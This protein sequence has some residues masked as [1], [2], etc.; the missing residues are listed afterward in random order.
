VVVATWGTD[1]MPVDKELA[2]GRT[3]RYALLVI[4]S[5][6]GTIGLL[7]ILYGQSQLRWARTS[8]D[9]PIAIGRIITSEI[10]THS[11]ENGITYSDEIEY[12]YTVEG[13]EYE[14]DVIVFGGHEYSAHKVVKKYPANA[15]VSVAYDPT[16][17]SRA[18]LEPGVESY[19]FQ[20]FG[21]SMWLG[22]VFMATLFN[23]ILRRAM[24]EEKNVLDKL[25]IFLFIVIFYPIKICDG[26]LWVLAGMIGLALCL[27]FLE[28]HPILTYG[29]MFFV[30][31]YGVLWALILWIHFM[32]WLSSLG[33]RKG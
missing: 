9:W 21:T 14:T 7:L 13:T 31:F 17:P 16:K 3:Q 29:S 5:I 19:G 10:T 32:G 30:A 8:V 15:E 12:R 28:F 33:E 20:K 24:N 23:F 1:E 6:F 2:K 18:V 27:T 22:S 11:D 25:L 4:W 26:N